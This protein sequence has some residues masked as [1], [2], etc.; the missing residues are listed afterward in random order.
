MIEALRSVPLMTMHLEVAFDRVL[1]IGD[2]PMG[3]RRIFPVNG[4]RFEGDRLRGTVL[5]DG[6]DW[7]LWRKDGA[8][9]IDVRLM[10]KTDDAAL[11][12]MQ[13]V[14]LMYGRTPEAQASIRKGESLTYESFYLRTTP[15]FE[16]STPGY[17]WLNRVIAVANG[18]LGSKGGVYHIFEVI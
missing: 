15:R 12:S 17:E 3:R 5:P 18:Q 16:T 2:I 13:Y 11:I 4:G 6:T 9:V 8:M 10:L 7:V 1:D 14:G